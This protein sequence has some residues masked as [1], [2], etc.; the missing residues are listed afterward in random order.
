MNAIDDLYAA[1]IATAV[2]HNDASADAIADPEDPAVAASVDDAGLQSI[3]AYQ[4]TVPAEQFARELAL[5]D[6]ALKH[7]HLPIVSAALLLMVRYLLAR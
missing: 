4:K 1:A 7:A 3:L 5:S 2:K 6:Y